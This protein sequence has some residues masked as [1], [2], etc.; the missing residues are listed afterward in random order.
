MTTK[1]KRADIAGMLERLAC[2]EVAVADVQAY[3]KKEWPS[4]ADSDVI[5]AFHFLQHFEADEDIRARDSDYSRSQLET[6]RSFAKR[7]RGR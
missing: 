7:L 3:F 4:D 6:L 2:G 5:D 1:A